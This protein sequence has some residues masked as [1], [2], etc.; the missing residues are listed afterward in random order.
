MVV[1]VI[2][3]KEYNIEDIAYGEVLDLQDQCTF[4]PDEGQPRLLRGK[5][6]RELILRAV[7]DKEGKPVDIN[8][9]N[10]ISMIDAALL[11]KA[12]GEFFKEQNLKNSSPEDVKV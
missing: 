12:V 10:Q 4:Y 2:N 7:K 9:K 3:E 1:K 11:D 8:N 5:Y 6:T